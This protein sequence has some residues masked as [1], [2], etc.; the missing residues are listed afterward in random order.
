MGTPQLEGVYQVKMSVVKLI[1]G[2][3]DNEIFEVEPLGQL[4]VNPEHTGAA[5]KN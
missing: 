1:D 5:F 2:V 3:K 4:I